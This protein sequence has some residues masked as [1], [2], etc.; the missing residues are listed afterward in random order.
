MTCNQCSK[1]CR[2]MVIQIGEIVT[3]DWIRWAEYHG[4]KILNI[5]GRYFIQINNECDKLVNGKCAIQG[6][7]PELC[8]RFYCQSEEYKEFKP[9]LYAKKQDREYPSF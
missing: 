6:I 7:K 1:C 3:P 9:L 4:V 5:K 8:Q 2:L